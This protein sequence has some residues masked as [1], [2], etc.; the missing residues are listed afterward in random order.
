[1]TALLRRCMEGAANL[2]VPSSRTSKPDIR[3]TIRSKVFRRLTMKIG[4]TGS[5][6][7]GKSTVSAYLASL[8]VP[9]SMPTRFPAR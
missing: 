4:L 5:I 8:A 6:A 9:L 2:R 7:C 3:G 1:M